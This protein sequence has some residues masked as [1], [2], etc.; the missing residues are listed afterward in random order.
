[1]DAWALRTCAHHHLQESRGGVKGRVNQPQSSTR[2]FPKN[3]GLMFFQTQVS[4]P[5]F[6]L[7]QGRA[8]PDADSRLQT[9]SGQ[10]GATEKGPLLMSH[11]PTTGRTILCFTGGLARF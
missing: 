3:T 4:S 9:C 1:M 10:H 8:D 2:S 11:V 7:R 5:W 6:R